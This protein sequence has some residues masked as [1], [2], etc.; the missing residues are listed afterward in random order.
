MGLGDFFGDIFGKVAGPIGQGIGT[1]IAQAIGNIGAP[2]P[3][4][5]VIT[6]QQRPTQFAT[7][8]AG[9]PTIAQATRAQ[10][11]GGNVGVGPLALPGG[12]PLR[13]VAVDA[14]GLEFGGPTEGQFFIPNRNGTRPANVVS[15]ADPDTGEPRFFG[16]LGRPLL[17]SRDMRAHRRVN[18]LASK[19]RR[20]S[21]G[22]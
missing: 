20:R 21:G 12:A 8:P 3:R 10:V 4:V 15:L 18:K 6:Q 16:H 7:R 22:R 19:A 14:F 5:Q 1:G 17:F 11:G 2:S 13:T 9:F